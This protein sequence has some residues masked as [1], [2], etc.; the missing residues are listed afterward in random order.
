M[1]TV[2]VIEADTASRASLSGE[3]AV[4]GFRTREFASSERFLTAFSHALSAC[5]I[6]SLSSPEVSAT[7]ILAGLAAQSSVMPVIVLYKALSM[8]KA[9]SLVKA[10]AFELLER[11]VAIGN[12]IQVVRD[13]TDS[14]AQFNDITSGLA[15]LS[16]REYEVM[17]L[18]LEVHSNKAIAKTLNISPKTSEKHRA[19]ILR[20]MQC[21]DYPE[22][23]RKMLP[24]SRRF[25]LSRSRTNSSPTVPA[26]APHE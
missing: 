17:R 26:D 16:D 23:M 14:H 2:F 21:D 6:V 20:K 10:G 4:S 11:S 8:R 15:E 7:D 3:L 5:V 24:A 1:P 25:G 9:V 12:L 22:L 19:N 13:A 18:F